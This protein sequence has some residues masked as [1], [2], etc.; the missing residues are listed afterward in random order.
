MDASLR[1]AHP[2]KETH[3]IGRLLEKMIDFLLGPPPPKP[4]PEPVPAPAPEPPPDPK[5]VAAQLRALADR[6]DPI[7]VPPFET[8]NTPYKGWNRVMDEDGTSGGLVKR[9]GAGIEMA[10]PP[11]D[12]TPATPLDGEAFREEVARTL[13]EK[14]G[15]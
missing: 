12:D 14:R 10:P 3:M 4:E 5:Q 13:G 6:L 9:K 2:D 8:P 7:V 1:D 15:R 11:D